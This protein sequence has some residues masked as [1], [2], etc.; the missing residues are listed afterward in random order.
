MQWILGRKEGRAP[1]DSCVRQMHTDDSYGPVL[2]RASAHWPWLGS[3]RQQSG[4]S[5]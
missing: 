1:V 2:R 3:E 4:V 5:L